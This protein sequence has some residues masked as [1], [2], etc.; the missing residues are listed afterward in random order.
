M[1]YLKILIAF[2]LLIKTNGSYDMKGICE[3]VCY[4]SK[5]KYAEILKGNESIIH[6]SKLLFKKCDMKIQVWSESSEVEND[7]VG[8]VYDGKDYKEI[9]QLHF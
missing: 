9:F 1:K 5:S 3:V 4:F 8:F 2:I 7:F 6:L